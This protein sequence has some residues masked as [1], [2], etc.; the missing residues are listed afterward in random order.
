[1]GQVGRTG[2]RERDEKTMVPSYRPLSDLYSVLLLC[3][4]S[5]TRKSIALRFHRAGEWVKECA[6]KIVV[7]SHAPR[8]PAAMDMAGFL[9]KLQLD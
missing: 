3:I 6:S 2:E 9:F 5:G 4:S 7:P 8:R 1:M